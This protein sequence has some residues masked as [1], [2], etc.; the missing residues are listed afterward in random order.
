MGIILQKKI[1]TILNR[2]PTKAYYI[3]VGLAIIPAYAF[4]YRL[5]T[6]QSTSYVA[7]LSNMTVNLAIFMF[8]VGIYTDMFTKK[9]SKGKTW[10]V[11]IVV[12][13]FMV[14]L[15]IYVTKL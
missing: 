11:R 15:L 2:I 5:L 3:L 12:V 8:L 1:S 9:M 6:D 10:L 14:L 13:A 4:G 7:I